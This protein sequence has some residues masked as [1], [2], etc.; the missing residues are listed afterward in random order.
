VSVLK[1]FRKKAKAEAD[2]FKSWLPEPKKKHHTL[3]SERRAWE[4][5]GAWRVDDKGEYW[6][7]EG[8]QLD[9]LDKINIKIE[10][11]TEFWVAFHEYIEANGVRKT[12]SAT[13]TDDSYWKKWDWKDDIKGS[14]TSL[15]SYWNP[16]SKSNAKWAGDIDTRVAIAMRAVQSTVRVIDDSGKRMTVA[17][18]TSYDRTI[19]FTDFD[20]NRIVISAKPITDK[21]LNEGQAI[22][23][24][25]GYGLHEASHS[26][27]TRQVINSDRHA[28]AEGYCGIPVQHR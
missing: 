6:W 11:D 23:V 28:D 17:P 3:R 19:A 27:Y 13:K 4:R 8:D 18:S 7:F 1:K 14:S 26:K 2:E 10:D 9:D 12:R 5:E 24:M 20:N 16:W 25:T 21:K 22:D 15:S